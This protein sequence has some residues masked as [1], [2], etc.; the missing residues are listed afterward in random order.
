MK[1]N[2]KLSLSLFSLRLGVFVVM[3]MWTIDKFINP[4]HASR[5]FSH[6]YKWDGLSETLSLGLGSLQLLVVIGFLA[7]YKKKYTYGAILAMHFV[8]TLSTYKMYLDPWGP[9]NLLFFAAWPMLAA[10][11]SL[12]LL[13][14][15]DTMFTV[16]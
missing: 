12:F 13:R 8:S 14:D 5:V 10:I 16:K 3:F 9:K 6:Y 15:E 7:G 2:K 11:F 1:K 4:E